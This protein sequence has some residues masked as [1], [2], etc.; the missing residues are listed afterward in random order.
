[1]PKL[2]KTEYYLFWWIVRHHYRTVR[3]MR[4]TV[5]QNR[6]SCNMQCVALSISHTTWAHTSVP[7]PL[8]KH[9]HA[10]STLSLSV[11]FTHFSLQRKERE[12]KGG[13]EAKRRR[14]R[15]KGGG[16][17]QPPRRSSAG[18]RRR[19]RGAPRHLAG[20]GG[21]PKAIIFNL[22]TW[23]CPKLDLPPC[24]VPSRAAS[25]GGSPRHGETPPKPIFFFPKPHVHF[26]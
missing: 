2:T 14:K 12:E 16:R 6:D 8:T 3:H 11:S 24:C 4:R 5:H 21:G 22:K 13:E 9:L 10:T 19:R 25:F 20:V 1:M 7:H 26:H 18:G 23:W 17:R 15:R